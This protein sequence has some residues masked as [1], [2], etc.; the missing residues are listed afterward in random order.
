MTQHA[1]PQSEWQRGWALVLAASVGFSFFSVMST[2]TGVFMKPL[3]DEFGWNR[4]MQASGTSVAAL[5]T[6]LLSPF[7]GLLIDRLGTRKLALPGLIATILAIAA[8]S[9]ASGVKWQWFALWSLYG[10]ISLSVKST[11]WTSAVT[12]MFEKG[13]GLALGLTLSGTAVATS[14]APPLAVWLIA[15]HGWRMAMVLMATGWGALALLLCGLFL[16]DAHDHR[17]GARARA[18]VTANLPDQTGLT[19]PQA[20]R[21]TALWRIA[22]T[23]FVMM[24]LTIGLQSN[25]QRMLT[26]NGYSESNAAW[27]S[28]LAGIA[29]IAGKL[30]TGQLL[31]RFRPNRVGGITLAITAIAFG[32]LHFA[33]A[34]TLAVTL[35]II[36]NGYAAGTKLQIAGFLTTRYGGLK[37][38]GAIFGMMASLIA[39]GSGLGSIAAARVHDL[40]GSYDLFFLAGIAGSLLCGLVTMTLPPYPRWKKLARA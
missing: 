21:D 10:I 4:T 40:T 25:L 37:N 30:I 7:F 26:D 20:W 34:S 18:G 2:T 1:M 9:Q 3:E 13:R 35:A 23:T 31:D 6:A 19:I 32:L 36:V 15:G 8:I 11:I 33:L 27:L 29:G 16:Y 12:G 22:L 17:S 5:W 24:V 38:F 28:S 14:L 39:V